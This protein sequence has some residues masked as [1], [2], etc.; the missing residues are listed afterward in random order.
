MRVCV[1]VLGSH[2]GR[3]KEKLGFHLEPLRFGR[4]DCGDTDSSLASVG[5][6]SRLFLF[7]LQIIFSHSYAHTLA[8]ELLFGCLNE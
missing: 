6:Q 7:L 3:D 8:C 1:S 2:E 5:N 4:A